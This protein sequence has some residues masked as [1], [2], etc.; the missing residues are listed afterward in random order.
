MKELRL[1]FDDEEFKKILKAKEITKLTWKK[2]ILYLVIVSNKEN[3][4]KNYLKI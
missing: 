4:K 1:T 3:L 2:W